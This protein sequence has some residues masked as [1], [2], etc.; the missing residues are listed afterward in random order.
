[1]NK[2]LMISHG[3]MAIGLQDT[4][5]LFLG[6]DHPFYAIGAYTCGHDDPDLEISEFM[7]TLSD[8]DC[9]IICTDIMGGSVN[10]KMM[11]YLTRK[12]TY[13]LSGLNLAMVL[14]L[15]SLINEDK[16]DYSILNNVIKETKDSII[17]VN[18]AF[19][20]MNAVDMDE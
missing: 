7:S 9:L 20:N 6:D 1:M 10:Q 5:T 15:S 4:L 18:E 13:I 14:Q 19:D 16:I 12:N 3:Q 17:N 11:S 8:D 2:F